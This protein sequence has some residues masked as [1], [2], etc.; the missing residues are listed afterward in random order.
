MRW[1]LPAMA[2]M[3]M[4]A[5]ADTTLAAPLVCAPA[6]A[7]LGFNIAFAGAGAATVAILREP[8]GAVMAKFDNVATAFGMGGMGGLPPIPVPPGMGGMSGMGGMWGMFGMNGMNG[9]N[10]MS[11]SS[12][13]ASTAMWQAP[14]V[15][16]PACYRVATMVGEP[17]ERH[18]A[19]WRIEG[20]TAI[21]AAAPDRPDAIRVTVAS[22][23][24]RPVFEAR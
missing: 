12:W 4:I 21:F 15:A 22:P 24:F 11:G 18:E 16:R 3:I 9:M 17:P 5:M 19:A 14:V 13:S 23:A 6:G 2:A 20:D 7:P 1:K 10:G 8:D